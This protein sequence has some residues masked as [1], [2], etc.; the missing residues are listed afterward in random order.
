MDRIVTATP[1]RDFVL[2][3]TERGMIYKVQWNEMYSDV[4]I[5]LI[6]SLDFRQ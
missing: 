4:T 3:F 6:S 5:Q 1:F 2:V